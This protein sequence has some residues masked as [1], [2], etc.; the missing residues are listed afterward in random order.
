MIF[1]KDI[2]VHNRF[3]LAPMAGI[4]D[5]PFRQICEGFGASLTY[6]EMVSAKALCFKDEKTST[7]LYL[8]KDRKPCF[9]QI[10]GHESDVMAEG[11]RR[12]LEISGAEGID[13]NMGCPV[14]KIVSNGE[15]SALMRDAKRAEEIIKA[16]RRVTDKP[17]TV[18]FRKGYEAGA[19]TC[20]EFAKMAEQAGVD[21]LCVH[22][23]TRSQLYSGRSDRGAIA[24][25]KASV[26]IPVIASG[27]VMTAKDAFDIF[28]ETGADFV[29]VARGAQGN[30]FIFDDLVRK[31]ENL[32]IAQRTP[33]MILDTMLR[34][35]EL[36]CAQKGEHKAI[37]EFR[38]HGLWYLGLFSGVK[39]FKLKMSQVSTYDGFAEL[40][41]EIRLAAPS[42]KEV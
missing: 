18:K 14:N 28:E 38:K 19:D 30:P 24:R 22:G 4:T 7:L 41:E 9:A 34:H 25:V 33:D 10:F 3:F 17:L 12:A 8:H 23:R 40:I 16:V 11:A 42:V 32:D 13:I 36:S 15:G 37:V 6:T 27:D 31:Q 39:A 5:D 29:M 20:V 26:N 2:E 35:I 21:A 1:C